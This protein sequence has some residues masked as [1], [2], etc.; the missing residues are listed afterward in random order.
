M[1]THLSQA[2]HH[3]CIWHV[4]R[5]EAALLYTLYQQPSWDSLVPRWKIWVVYREKGWWWA[6]TPVSSHTHVDT[7]R[8]SKVSAASWGQMSLG[9]S[10]R[11]QAQLQVHGYNLQK[12]QQTNEILKEGTVI[13]MMFLRFYIKMTIVNWKFCATFICYPMIFLYSNIL[14][15]ENRLT[16]HKMW[17]CSCF[18][19][20]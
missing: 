10:V 18:C 2:L 20:R 19:L 4:Q 16:L 1:L 11:T 14:I 17:L 6:W 3:S 12:H 5:N 7:S 9:R 13:R 15:H 8:W